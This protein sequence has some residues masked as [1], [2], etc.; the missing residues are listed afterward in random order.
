MERGVWCHRVLRCGESII[1]WRKQQLLMLMHRLLHLAEQMVSFQ[2]KRRQHMRRL[3]VT[4]SPAGRHSSQ[5]LL[6][7]SAPAL[8]ATPF[9][10]SGSLSSTP[11]TQLALPLS[12]L[13]VKALSIHPPTLYSLLFPHRTSIHFEKTNKKLLFK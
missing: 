5:A 3:M 9:H 4:S 12:V 1:S 7:W 11:L 13:P 6:Q 8:T 2:S 10:P